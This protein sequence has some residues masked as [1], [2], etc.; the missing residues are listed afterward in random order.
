[1]EID[2]GALFGVELE[3]GAEEQEVADPA[4]NQENPAGAGAEEQEVADPAAEADSQEQTVAE[5]AAGDQD[6]LN[7]E[8]QGQSAE[9]NAR[10]VAARRKAE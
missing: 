5:T 6:G 9:E 1:M 8:Q 2:Y 3:H 4:E 7:S 10:Y